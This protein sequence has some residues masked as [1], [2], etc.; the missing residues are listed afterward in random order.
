MDEQTYN[1]IQQAIPYAA[2][3]IAFVGGLASLCKWRAK[4]RIAEIEENNYAA[5]AKSDLESETAEAEQDL[6][7]ETMKAEQ[8]LR[9]E[10]MKAENAPKRLAALQ[11]LVNSQGYLGVVRMR[12]EAAGKLLDENTYENDSDTLKSDIDAIVGEL[13]TLDE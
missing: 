3:A 7:L 12:V 11:E 9:L 13:P 8:E 5:R 6:K 10:T 1:L 4:V 2:G